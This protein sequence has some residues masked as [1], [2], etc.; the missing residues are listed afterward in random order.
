MRSFRLAKAPAFCYTTF[1]SIN[2][3][4]F[5][6]DKSAFYGSSSRLVSTETYAFYSKNT[7]CMGLWKKQ[8]MRPICLSSGARKEENEQQSDRKPVSGQAAEG[9]FG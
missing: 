5:L 8:V 6:T 2:S 1:K 3:L 9:N 7:N 4:E